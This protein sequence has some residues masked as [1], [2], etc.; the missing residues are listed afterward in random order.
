MSKNNDNKVINYRKRRHLNVGLVIFGFTFIYLLVMIFFY[1]TRDRITIY[2]IVKDS[3]TIDENISY[4]G[5]IIRDETLTYANNSGYI[6]FYA[7][8]SEHISLNSGIYTISDNIDLASSLDEI[9]SS[10]DVMDEN[11]IDSIKDNINQF[12]RD[13]SNVNFDS[14]YSFKFNMEYIVLESYNESLNDT[15]GNIVEIQNSKNTGTLVYT[16]DNYENLSINN[17]NSDIFNDNTYNKTILKSGDYVEQGDV[18]FKTITSEQWSLVFPLSEDDAELY[19]NSSRL[20]VEFLA[21]NLTE[22]GTFEI[23]NLTD[24]TYGKLTFNKYCIRYANNRFL[25]MKI[26]RDKITGLKIPKLSVVEKDF[27]VIPKEYFFVANNAINL[28]LMT[29]NNTSE[30]KKMKIYFEDSENYYISTSDLSEGDIITK[31]DSQDTFLVNEKEKLKGV[32]NVN[33]GYAEFE[34]INILT[35]INDYYII[36]ESTGYSPSQYDYIVLDGSMV[37][38]NEVVFR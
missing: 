38:E 1:F 35:E 15:G 5:I 25:D 9:S 8:D 16:T 29:E 13:F 36:N 18:I 24:G 28:N 12:S 17:I 20:R 10:S 21:D 27:Y 22:T 23:L 4:K 32:Y 14:V 6:N 37:S 19:K 34:Y 11:T 2:E 30:L 31:L 33:N 3:V 7:C 26:I